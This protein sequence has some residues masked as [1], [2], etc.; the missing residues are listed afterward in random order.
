MQATSILRAAGSLRFAVVL[1][2]LLV[3]A[4]ACA[5]VFESSVGTEQALMTAYD[6]HSMFMAHA[7]IAGTSPERLRRYIHVPWA[8][9]GDLFYLHKL[10]DTVKAYR[11]VRWVGPGK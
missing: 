5:T 8:A 9:R 6:S 4:M 10:A 7:W 2:M 3:V 11:G 1:L